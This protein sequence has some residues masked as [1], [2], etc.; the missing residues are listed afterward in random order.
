MGGGREYDIFKI[1]IT[2]KNYLH[3]ALSVEIVSPKEN[4]SERWLCESLVS[5]REV[6]S[7]KKQ[8]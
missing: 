2:V 4:I 8:T 6:Y 7:P 3:A 1:I 5:E